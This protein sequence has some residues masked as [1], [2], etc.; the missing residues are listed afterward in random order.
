MDGR[1]LCRIQ[2]A[3]G[4]VVVEFQEASRAR[5]LRL[6][7]FQ[8]VR[9]TVYF[10]QVSPPLRQHSS[11]L[12]KTS[13]AV[14]SAGESEGEPTFPSCAGCYQRD[15]L[16]SHLIK[17]MKCVDSQDWKVWENHKYWIPQILL[18]MLQT[19]SIS[20]PKNRWGGITL[21]RLQVTPVLLST[22]TPS[23]TPWLASCVHSPVEARASLCRHLLSLCR[24]LTQLCE[25]GGKHM[26]L[27]IPHLPRESKRKLL[28]FH[29]LLQE[30]EGI[31]SKGHPHKQE[32]EV[33]RI[34]S[35]KRS[36]KA[37]ESLTGMTKGISSLYLVSKD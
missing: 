10:T 33:Q 32:Q 26:H 20:M 17:N 23:P 35:Q 15:P 21:N 30:D 9:E 37:R 27:S 31:K 2:E 22:H 14:I 11:A 25:T 36:E 16:L 7:A 3:S 8:R 1:R 29:L 18:N 13:S 4:E 12:S 6:D 28:A 34:V 24:K 19:P 5:S